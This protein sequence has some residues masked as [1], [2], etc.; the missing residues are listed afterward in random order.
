MEERQDPRTRERGPRGR[1]REWGVCGAMISSVQG[2][3]AEPP[4]AVYVTVRAR[5]T[6]HFLRRLEERGGDLGRL[7]VEGDTIVADGWLR[8]VHDHDFNLVVSGFG[9]I[10]IRVD[11]F[12]G[13]GFVAVTFLPLEA[14]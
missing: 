2:L 12:G 10:R 1:D 13:G 4:V 11:R 6:D 8:A 3:Q 7:L 14:S 9:Q 5:L